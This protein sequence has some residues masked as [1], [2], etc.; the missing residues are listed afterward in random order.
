MATR[1][2]TRVRR[3][4]VVLVYGEDR[5]DTEAIAELIQALCPDL[6]GCVKAKPSPPVLIRDAR[7]ADVPSRAERILADVRAESVT[8]DVVCVFAH[9]DC[10]DYAPSHVAV[11]VKIEDAFATL[12]VPV[13]AVTPSWE[14][15]AWFFLWP[16]AVGAYRQSW[17]R[18]DSY[19]NRDTGM[20]KDAKETLRRALRPSGGTGGARDYRES[21]APKIAAKVRE[22]GLA[23]SPEARNDS[24]SQFS[25]RVDACCR[26]A[27]T[28]S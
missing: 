25:A 11:S 5:N 22:L 10:D 27:T 18:L 3:P 13:H 7:A 28:R 26:S 15:E 2:S 24:Y 1:R 14:L 19:R 20:I 16:T 9:E 8:R 23:R 12:G 4:K 6:V 17:R 21:D